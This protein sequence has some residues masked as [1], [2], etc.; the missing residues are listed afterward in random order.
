MI[1]TSMGPQQ[2]KH[3]RYAEKNW[4]LLKAEMYLRVWELWSR[5]GSLTVLWLDTMK[6][7]FTDKP[8]FPTPFLSGCPD[9]SQAPLHCPYRDTYGQ[10]REWSKTSFLVFSSHCTEDKAR[11]AFWVVDYPKRIKLSCY[12]S[13]AENTSGA[14]EILNK[15]VCPGFLSLY[16]WEKNHSPLD[17]TTNLIVL[18]IIIMPWRSTKCMWLLSESLTEMWRIHTMDRPYTLIVLAPWVKYWLNNYR[19]KTHYPRWP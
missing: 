17:M 14:G 4:S 12:S 3:L 7:L 8:G 2:L 5:M 11:E 19:L 18:N 13:G 1:F 10:Y 15:L 16:K 9:S 6:T